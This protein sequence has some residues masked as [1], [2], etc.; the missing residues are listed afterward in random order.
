VR[1]GAARK[2]ALIES[3]G[4]MINDKGVLCIK[5]YNDLGNLHKDA[6]IESGG[7]MVNDNG[8]C[9]FVLLTRG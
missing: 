8:V 9:C 3:G 7:Y 2:D 1:N 6:L 5:G 4:Y